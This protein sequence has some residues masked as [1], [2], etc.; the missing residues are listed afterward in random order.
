M[1]TNLYGVGDNYHPQ[2]SHVIP[3]L[4]R[5]FHSAKSAG[6]P[7]VIIWG[8]GTP[9]REFLYVDDLAAASLHLLRLNDPPDWVNVGSGRE[10]TI[11]ELA[12]LIA[13]TV[14]YT[15]R[16][17][18]DADMPDGTPRKLLDSSALFATGWRPVVTLEEGLAIAY[19][20][21]LNSEKAG[22]LRSV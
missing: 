8:S 7:D 3:G 11:L 16:I 21:Y 20:E 18:P 13:R 12:V 14:G 6:A 19:S 1:P 4:I 9:L 17:I 2:N 10:L 15:G 22:T 5:R